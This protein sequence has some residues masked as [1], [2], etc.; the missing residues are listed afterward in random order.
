MGAR[1]TLSASD[2]IKTAS[3][4]AH[5]FGFRAL[6]DLKKDKR[7]LTCEKVEHPKIPAL[8]KRTDALQGVLTGGL[9]AYFDHN[10]HALGE[11]ALFY[12]IEE[13]PRNGD[14]AIALQILGIEKS[15]AEALLIHTS[16]SLLTELGLGEHTVRINSLG[17]R[18]SMA[19]YT[20]EL[21]NYLKKRMELMPGAARELMKEHALTALAHLIERDH[22]LGKKSPSPLE[23]LNETSRKHFRE[24]IEYL[25]FSETPY[26]IDGKLMGHHQC[27]SQ[28]LFSIDAFHDEERTIPASVQVRGGRY[29]EFAHQIAKRHIPAVGAVITLKEQTLPARVPRLKVS[30]PQVFMVQLGFGPKLRSLMILE[31]LK[32]AQIPVYQSLAS[33]SLSGQLERARSYNVPFTIILGQKEYVENIVIVRDMR[34]SSQEHV[35]MSGLVAHL[36]KAVR[37]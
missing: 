11:P 36:R 26:E 3:S 10:L 1:A 35:P 13:T 9:S 27:Y 2:F 31:E 16:R 20:R 12:S 37:A 15:I 7:C 32:Q 22:E 28:T 8:Q 19:R 5:H 30:A 33:D 18:E 23:Y 14:I 29:D 24:I 21:G 4:T 6:D 34:S 25:D 17:D